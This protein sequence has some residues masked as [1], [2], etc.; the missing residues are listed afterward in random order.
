VRRTPL[1][2]AVALTLG[3]LV[4]GSAAASSVRDLAEI[5]GM[6]E[7]KIFGV[8][9]VVGLRGTGDKGRE[10]QRRIAVL[11]KRLKFT[12]DPTDLPSKNVALVFVTAKIR[13][14]SPKG[15]RI[16]VTVAS[17][18]DA[19]SLDGGQLLPT[20]LHTDKPEM[21]CARA[22]GTVSV[23][24]SLHY[25]AGTIS[26]G[27]TVEREISS[28]ALEKQVEVKDPDTGKSELLYCFDLVLDADSGTFA[29]ANDIADA[30]NIGLRRPEKKPAARALSPTQIQVVI[31]KEYSQKRVAF[32]R[33]I[34]NMPV[35]VD[36]PA[37][38]IINERTGVVVA[39][40]NV[41]FSAAE[42]RV[43][44]Q[45]VVIKNDASFADLKRGLA[46][47]GSDVMI[48]VIKELSK[49]GALQAK[50]VSR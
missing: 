45:E 4:S 24:G 28:K 1:T 29:L 47:A 38:V 9:L 33:D 23:N 5:K 18:G 31:P 35:V 17:M 50:L 37:K 16:D 44:T 25:T 7:H 2:L 32:V 10:T 6:R 26:K 11:L 21:V 12:V 20:P 14:D 22:Q 19:T 48:A 39:T 3:L 36:P 30:I 41:R 40:G 15:T 8:G 49:A 34:L 13:S 46:N 42:V 27:A 43:G